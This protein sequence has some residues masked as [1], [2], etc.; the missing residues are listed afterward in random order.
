MTQTAQTVDFTYLDV[1]QKGWKLTIVFTIVDFS[2]RTSTSNH[3]STREDE[4]EEDDHLQNRG[5]ILDFGEDPVGAS[6]NAERND[7]DDGHC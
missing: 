4:D 7:Q 6:M 1:V 5:G 2:C 3:G